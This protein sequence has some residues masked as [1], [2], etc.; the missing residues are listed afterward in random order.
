MT[1]RTPHLNALIV[2]VAVGYA[3]IGT[4]FGAASLLS[5]PAEPAPPPPTAEVVAA[6]SVPGDAVAN[7]ATLKNRPIFTMSRRP[8]ALEP[9]AEP[10]PVEEVAQTP[11]FED[12]QVIA[13]AI[14]GEEAMA[15]LQS[16]SGE[17]ARLKIGSDLRGWVV[18][19][20]DRRG[21]T[22]ESSGE[23]KRIDV[24]KQTSDA[25]SDQVQVGESAP[26]Q[27]ESATP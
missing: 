12:F 1:L 24:R 13:V 17:R 23:E 3:L 9:A 26:E 2:S 10:L 22:L 20:I 16:S 6:L 14:K 11:G 5:S 19:A 7:T 25:A 27:P 4:A 18:K 8:R 15:T 21:V